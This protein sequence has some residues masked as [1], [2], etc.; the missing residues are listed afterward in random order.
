MCSPAPVCAAPRTRGPPVLGL[1]GPL[2]FP[3]FNAIPRASARA[4]T[5]IPAK[6]PPFY[7]TDPGPLH[8]AV[9]IPARR[10]PAGPMSRETSSV[11]APGRKQAGSRRIRGW[12][13]AHARSSGATGPDRGNGTPGA[14]RRWHDIA[15]APPAAGLVRWR[16][17]A[18]GDRTRAGLLRRVRQAPGVRAP[19][20]Q[21]VL[22]DLPEVE[23]GR[24]GQ[25]ARRRAHG[26]RRPA[27]ETPTV[28]VGNRGQSA[29]PVPVPHA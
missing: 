2:A 16:G 4:T 20:G 15:P 17:T 12:D 24:W 3:P 9:G 18:P 19:G 10:L 11:S 7:V 28:A 27:G 1:G 5:A 21:S 22:P 14:S 25:D 13:D 6:T 8:H 29:R 26:R 23:R